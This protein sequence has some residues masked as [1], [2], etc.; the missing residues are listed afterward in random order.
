ML[1]RGITVNQLAIALS[2]A[3]GRLQRIVH[4]A[5]PPCPREVN[6]LAAEIGATP[7]ELFTDEARYAGGGEP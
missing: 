3:Y 1:Q 7:R 4:G 2:V 5:T 6:K